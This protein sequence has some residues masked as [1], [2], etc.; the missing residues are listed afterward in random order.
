MANDLVSILGRGEKPELK[1]LWNCMRKID[2]R[3]GQPTKKTKLTYVR[4]GLAKLM[5]FPPDIRPL[6]YNYINT[7]DLIDSDD[8]P[9]YL[10]NL[11]LVKIG[12]NEESFE[13]KDQ[14]IINLVELLGSASM[15]NRYRSYARKDA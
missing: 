9:T 8:I 15:R 7:G 6:I 13:I 5:L 3:I 14:E 2:Q 4:N 1:E 12:L 10:E 11:E